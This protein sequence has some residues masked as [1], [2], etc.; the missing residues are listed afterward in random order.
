MMKKIML[1]DD[2]I[3]QIRSIQLALEIEYGDEY[4]IIPVQSGAECLNLLRQNI[5]PVL[6]LLDIMM[7]AMT[8]WIV[9]EQVKSS[10]QWKEIP[11]VFLTAVT[12]EKAKIEGGFHDDDFIHKPVEPRELKKRIDK[13]LQQRE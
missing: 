12:D 9:Y 7:P 5:I 10:V 6:I 4:Q 1:V 11:I 13:A 3:D 8:G 2:E